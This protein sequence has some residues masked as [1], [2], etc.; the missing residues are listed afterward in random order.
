MKTYDAIIIG[1]GPAGQQAGLFLGRA[2]IK[3]LLIGD[4]AQSELA[5]GKTIDN[6]FGQPDSP[7]GLSLLQNGIGH[8][9]RFGVEVLKAEIV[10]LKQMEGGFEAVTAG[11][12]S[13]GAKAVIIATGAFLPK[14]GIRGEKDFLGKGVHTCVACDG[15][16]FKQKAVVV[17][18]SGPHAAEEAIE[19]RAHTDRVAIYAQ[20]GKWE[21][22]E[23][24]T[25]KVKELGIPMEAK[26]IVS[27]EGDGKVAKATLADKSVMELDGVFVAM[28]TAGGVTF[29]NK[30]GLIMED[31]YLKI[32]R[33]GKTNI[34]GVW[35]AGSVTG[36]N[37]QISKSAGEGC[38]AAISIIKTLKGL[39]NYVDQT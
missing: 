24:L 36:G 34:P 21:M 23:A 39:A 15:P 33:D 6:F 3:T 16:F 25:A 20:G 27:V 18:G 1:A 38:N 26:R 19:L 28:G 4:P 31:D 29:S 9:E 8:L 7:S 13:C 2:G 30:L 22:G 12:E 11:L 35:A 37:H 14:A 17:V 5:F 10:D 32:D